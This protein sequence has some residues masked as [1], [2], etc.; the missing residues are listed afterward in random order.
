MC[1]RFSRFRIRSNARSTCC[2]LLTQERQ[3]ARESFFTYVLSISFINRVT[4]ELFPPF[5][6]KSICLQMWNGCATQ[7]NLEPSRH[8][9]KSTL[10]Y[11]SN[12]QNV[13]CRWI[14]SQ[15]N[16][17]IRLARVNHVLSCINEMWTVS[18]WHRVWVVCGVLFM[19]YFINTYTIH[20]S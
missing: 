20:I 8:D 5:A 10:I 16:S 4:Q 7:M 12:L 9:S 14:V 3:A 19:Y 18:R 15:V 1:N 2:E 13:H 11:G 17:L 6:I